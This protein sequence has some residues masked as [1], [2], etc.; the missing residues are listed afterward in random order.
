MSLRKAF[1]GYLEAGG[2]VTLEEA[3]FGKPPQRAGNY[4]QRNRESERNFR[5]TLRYAEELRKPRKLR[6]G[7]GPADRAAVGMPITGKALTRIAHSDP[8][9]TKLIADARS[10]RAVSA[11]AP[12]RRRTK[13]TK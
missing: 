5:A 1:E 4:A 11:P 10:R 12:V 6:G 3:F 7:K 13:R 2:S 8:R 9:L